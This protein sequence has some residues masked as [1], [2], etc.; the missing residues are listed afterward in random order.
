MTKKAEKLKKA[1]A[2]A[3]K[4]F[5][6]HNPVQKKSAVKS[7]VK[8]TPKTTPKTEESVEIPASSKKSSMNDKV[9]SLPFMTG[10]NDKVDISTLGLKKKDEQ[11]NLVGS[12]KK[13][14]MIKKTG[15]AKV[16]KGERV[17]TAKQN[18]KLSNIIKI[19]KPRKK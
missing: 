19:A 15:T 2:R 17:L 5:A 18:K 12:Y 4:D 11:L 13:G 10:K 6:K 14:G 16:H 3:A 9:M 7:A 8:A 1:K